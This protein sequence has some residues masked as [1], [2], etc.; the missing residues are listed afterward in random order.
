[1]LVVVVVLGFL[2]I[3]LTQGV[4]AGLTLWEAQS[5]RIGE[6][7]ELDAAARILRTLLS[8]IVRPR[9]PLSSAPDSGAAAQGHRRQPRLYRRSAD[10]ARNHP[11]R[12]YHH[13]APQGRLVLRWTPRRHELV[14]VR[15]R[16]NPPKSSW[17]AKSITSSSPIGER[18]LP[19]QPAAW[20]VQWDGVDVPDLIR[21]RLGFARGRPAPFP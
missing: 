13:R 21:V 7:A 1:M 10:R 5:R 6:T 4:R 15:R 12:Q 16:P 20:Q 14:R 8:G 17:F 2:M 9:R 3:G 18:W 19:D 11:A